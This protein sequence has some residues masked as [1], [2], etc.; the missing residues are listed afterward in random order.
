MKT[1]IMH[2]ISN[3]DL[4]ALLDSR[5]D[6][7]NQPDFIEQD[8]IFVPHQF[9]KKQDIEIVGLVT[10]L[11]AWGQRKTIKNKG[12]E[13][14]RLMDNSPYEFIL[15]HKPKDLKAFLNFKHRTFNGEDALNLIHF[16]RGHF[17]KYDSLENAFYE[18]AFSKDRWML[19]GLIKFRK[20]FES[21]VPEK[22]R[23]LKHIASPL[24]NSSC[25]RLNMYL[26]WM[27][28]KDDRGVDFGLWN[29]IS[30]S[31]LLC[32][33]DL[34]VGKVA[35]KLSLLKREQNDIRAVVELSEALRAFDER[36]PCKY[37]FALFSL[38]VIEHFA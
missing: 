21:A 22:S 5:L 37:D 10:A 25:K 11:F 19:N 35:R 32:P 24:K 34:H 30:H 6:H 13:F 33:L 3:Q 16:L 2:S 1:W 18:N 17:N 26:R 38:G 8:P 29:N 27:V 4:K 12:L 15:D 23:T 28:R 9:S 31:Q 7:Y 36:D 14:A 20:Y